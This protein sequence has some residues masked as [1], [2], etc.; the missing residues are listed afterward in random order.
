MNYTDPM[1]M[2]SSA[3]VTLP[4]L[5]RRINAEAT[6]EVTL[7]DYQPEIRRVLSVTPTVLPP[8]KYV[9]GSGVELSGTVDYSVLYV[10]ADGELYTLPMSSEY[11]LTLPVEGISEFDLGAGVTVWADVIPEGVSFRVSSPRK[12]SVRCRLRTLVRAFGKLLMEERRVGEHSSERLFRRTAAAKNLSVAVGLSDLVSLS[13]ELSGIADGSRVISAEATPTVS[14]VRVEGEMARLS[15]EVLLRLLVGGENRSPSV[16]SRTLPLSGEVELECAD[17]ADE[18]RATGTVSEISVEMSEDGRI[19]CDLSVLLE[20][21]GMS[22][23]EV[24]YTADLFSGAQESACEHREYRLPI[25]LGCDRGNFSQSER[26]ALEGLSLPEGCVIHDAWG[27]VLFDACEAVGQ[28]YVFSG[29][30]KYLLLCEKDGEFSMAELSLPIRYETEGGEECPESY[31]VKG[32]VISCRARID[33]EMLSLDSEIAVIADFIGYEE[34][35][36]VREIRFGEALSTRGSRM[37]VYYPAADE[38]AWAVAKKY[39]M[40]PERIAKGSSYYYF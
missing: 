15:G 2:E 37:T 7:P 38:D 24:I 32:S 26:I 20:V 19:L 22:N 10:G 6:G 11:H 9:G 18:C 3:Y 8:A 39:H 40:P 13:C 29:E 31:S 36:A 28:K 34:I 35:S 4:I 21:R 16:I 17:A 5:E 27:S 33:G 1:G 25:A 30:S 23:R 14:E 12:M